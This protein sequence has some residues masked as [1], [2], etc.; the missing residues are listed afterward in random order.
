V[1]RATATIDCARPALQQNHGR[2]RALF[3]EVHA[4]CSSSSPPLHLL[5]P[6]S[7]ISAQHQVPDLACPVV[8]NLYDPMLACCF[9][10]FRCGRCMHLFFFQIK[11][12]NIVKIRN[13][14]RLCKNAMT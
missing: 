6:V 14:C 3:R 11:N 13:T 2:S 12:I 4:P 9:L 10:S 8:L 5:L 1:G 7:R